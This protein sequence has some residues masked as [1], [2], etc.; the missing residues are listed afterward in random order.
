MPTSVTTSD[1]VLDW[2]DEQDQVIGQTDRKTANSDPKF[3]HRE[4]GVLIVDPDNRVLAQ[5]RAAGKTDPGLWI[6]SA[7]GHVKKGALPA[8][9]AQ[10]ELQE[11]LGF[12]TPLKFIEKTFQNL[13]NES[14]FL[15]FF[16]GDFP[17]DAEIDY[18]PTEVAEVKWF[19]EEEL[20]EALA[21][22]E[23]FELLSL[24]AFRRFWRGEFE[25]STDSLDVG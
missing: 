22:G 6:L 25:T 13:P 16:I 23:I 2:V 1:E 11:E 10:E 12:S 14:R 8:D 3:T 20:E 5:R 15:Y 18:D 4:V 24:D 21:Q 17:A 9:S 19:S 7:A